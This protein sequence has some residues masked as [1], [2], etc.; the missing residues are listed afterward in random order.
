MPKWSYCLLINYTFR[1]QTSECSYV[2]SYNDVPNPCFLLST[3]YFFFSQNYIYVYILLFPNYYIHYYC[4]HYITFSKL[5]YIY[6][7]SQVKQSFRSVSVQLY[8]SY[9]TSYVH[10]RGRGDKEK[11]DIFVLVTTR[12]MAHS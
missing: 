8:L 7:K 2:C 3:F 5:L 9:D 4:I 6:N 12:P 11:N 1:I 10:R